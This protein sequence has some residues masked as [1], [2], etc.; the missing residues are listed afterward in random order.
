MLGI[1]AGDSDTVAAGLSTDFFNGLDL[2]SSAV[3]FSALTDTP[4]FPIVPGANVCRVAIRACHNI[5]RID[6]ISVHDI[7]HV[8][9]TDRFTGKCACA[10]GDGGRSQN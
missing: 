6:V 1:T 3:I 5:V 7:F 4:P 9:D 10:D 8:L 2:F